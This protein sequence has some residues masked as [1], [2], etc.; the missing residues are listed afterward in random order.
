MTDKQ[1]FNVYL[2]PDL[3][4]RVKHR[5]VDVEKSLSV[6]VEDMLEESL[7]VGTD[8][9]DH[10]LTPLTI[11]Y[12]SEMERS[13]QFYEA[14][15]FTVNHRGSVW[16]ELRMGGAALAL[17]IQEKPPAGVQQVTLAFVA[18]GKLEALTRQL[19]AV[20]ITPEG[21]I[22]DEAFGRFIIVSDPDGLRIQINEHDPDLYR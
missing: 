5:A 12:V 20:G 19:Q 6:Y 2:P 14:L 7:A 4:R 1:Q 13:V 9:A 17:H 18:A 11:V 15:G 22:A 3:I 16:S 21:E 8:R 10:P